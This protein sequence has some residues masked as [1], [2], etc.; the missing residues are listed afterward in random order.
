VTDTLNN[1]KGHVHL[2]LLYCEFSEQNN[3]YKITLTSLLN[4]ITLC[5]DD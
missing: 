5:T 1:L 4:T 3:I 2:P